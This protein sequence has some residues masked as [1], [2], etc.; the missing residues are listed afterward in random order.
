LWLSQAPT[1]GLLGTVQGLTAYLSTPMQSL[2]K[3]KK[4][5]R[6]THEH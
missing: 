5:G 4:S 2:G 6:H 3:A 1:G